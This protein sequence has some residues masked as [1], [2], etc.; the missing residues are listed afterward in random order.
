[1]AGEKFRVKRLPGPFAVGLVLLIAMVGGSLILSAMLARNT[2]ASARLSEYRRAIADVIGGARD[3]EIGQRGYLLTHDPRYLEPY[4]QALAT[5]RPALDRMTAQDA[6]SATV[7]RE[8][9]PTIDEKLAELSTTIA[10]AKAGRQDEAMQ[11]VR[12]NVGKQLMDRV[13]VV[14]ERERTW[15]IAQSDALSE[16]S[17]NAVRFLI[18]G[19]MSGM[20]AIL[21]LTVIWSRQSARQYAAITQARGYAERALADLQEEVRSR[22]QTQAQVRQ[23]QKMQAVGQLTG[24]IAHDFNNMLAIITSGIE[25]AKR[26]LRTDLAEAETFLEASLDG[27]RRAA[28]LTSRLLAF[29]RNQPLAPQPLDVNRLLTGM[30]EMMTRA[31]GESVTY[32]AVYAPSPWRCYADGS[33]VENAL[34]NLAVNARDAMPGGGKLTIST[35]NTTIAA[36]EVA[37]NIEVTRG[38]YVEICVTDTG[39]GMPPEVAAQAFDPFFTTKDVGKG[40]GLGLSQVFGFAR[41]SGGH[42]SIDTEPGKGTTIRLLLPRF[43]GSEAGVMTAVGAI[44]I[45]TGAKSE[46]ILVVED[47]VRVRTFA[48][49]VLRELG[50]TAIAASSPADA[51]R[52]IDERHDLTLMFTDIVMPDMNGSELAERARAMRP[53]LKILFTTGYTRDTVVKEGVIDVGVALLSKPYTIRDIARKV[54]D[55]LDGGGINRPV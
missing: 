20:A 41:Q 48:T 42:A 30:T 16:R 35:H 12:T 54:R 44:D 9:R 22:E 46:I 53:D 45:P 25:L 34:L 8:L 7:A 47:E 28:A 6:R 27:A 19:L 33:E 26:R 15:A 11:I 31:L 37:T 39:H 23:L 51:L 55:V 13:R 36:S 5:V 18:L 24:G 49:D 50:Y 21:F 10:L 29:A 43:F 38:E 1:M 2:S 32:E 3:A 52:L 14:F 40:T 4:E 17:A